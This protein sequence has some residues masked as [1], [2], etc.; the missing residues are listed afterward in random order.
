MGSA[1]SSMQG[2]DREMRLTKDKID[3][4]LL[5]LFKFQK[6]CDKDQTISVGELIDIFS[7]KT[8]VFMSH[9]WGEGQANHKKVAEINK[10]L[11]DRGLITWVGLICHFL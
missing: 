9:N 5:K 2:V 4:L 8:D 3:P 10:G 11:K 6:K 1:A 7:N